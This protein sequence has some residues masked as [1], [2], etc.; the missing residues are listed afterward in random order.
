[1]CYVYK[2]THKDRST[3]MFV[4]V[5][6]FVCVCNLWGPVRQT[7][8]FFKL[9]QQVKNNAGKVLNYFVKYIDT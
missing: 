5:R 8:Q 6:V 1:M 3:I 4:C 7:K 9:V 2:S